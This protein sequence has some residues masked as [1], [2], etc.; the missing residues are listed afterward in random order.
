MKHPIPPHGAI[1][2]LAINA[3]DIDRSRTFYETLFGWS[4]HPWGPPG[5]YRIETPGGTAIRAAL[6]Q[7]RDLVESVRTIG[8]ECTVAVDDLVIALENA[9]ELGGTI[10]MDSVTIPSV[11][12]LAMVEDPGGNVVGM[13]RYF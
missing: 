12:D 8:F 7:R 2:H 3:G 6:Q 11:C 10:V 5:F 9:V 1:A 13:A 4:F